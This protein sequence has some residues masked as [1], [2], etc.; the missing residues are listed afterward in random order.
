MFLRLFLRHRAATLVQL[1]VLEC[2]PV[3]D[4]AD[5]ERGLELIRVSESERPA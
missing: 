3:I 2:H 1:Q 5:G 4:L